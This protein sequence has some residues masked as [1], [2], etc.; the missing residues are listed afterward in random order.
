MQVT[1]D[2]FRLQI[3]LSSDRTT[4]RI[5][6]ISVLG[7]ASASSAELLQLCTIAVAPASYRLPSD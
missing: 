5:A 4:A 1:Q 6:P 2:K 7:I 3:Q